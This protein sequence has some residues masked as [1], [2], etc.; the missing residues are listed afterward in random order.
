MLQRI[1]TTVLGLGLFIVALFV[2]SLLVA[3]AVAAAL[4]AWT[5]A[6]WRGRRSVRVPAAG[7]RVIEGEYRIVDSK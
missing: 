5:W 6:W 3:G 4:L 7:G 2:T 1:L